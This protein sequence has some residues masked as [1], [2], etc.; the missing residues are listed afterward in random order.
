MPDQLVLIGK[1]KPARRSS[2]GDDQ[3]ACLYRFSSAEIQS[4]RP[5]HQISAHQMARQVLRA[6]TRGLLAH[7]LDQFRP[8]DAL[9]KSR[10]ILHQ[11]SDGK[12]PARLMPF[13]HQRLQ[14]GAPGVDGRSQAGAA[15]TQDHSIANGIFHSF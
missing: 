7:V 3:R 12:L 9:W 11:R 5:L 8:L 4:E 2:A 13:D 6:K 1:P 10:E 14:V 15:G